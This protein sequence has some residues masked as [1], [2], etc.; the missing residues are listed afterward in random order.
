MKLYKGK[1]DTLKLTDE[2]INLLEW[3]LYSLIREMVYI[4]QMLFGF[5]LSSVCCRSLSHLTSLYFCLLFLKKSFDGVSSQ[6]FWWTLKSL[7][8]ES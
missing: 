4:E 6:V 8:V 2:V 7:G 1:S 3:V 5:M